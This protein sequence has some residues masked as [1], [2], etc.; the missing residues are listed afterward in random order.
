VNLTDQIFEANRVGA[1][2]VT[3]FRKFFYQFL[4]QLRADGKSRPNGILGTGPDAFS[5]KARHAT[6][7]VAAKPR[8]KLLPIALVKWLSQR[9]WVIWKW[10]L[11][12]KGE[13]TKVLYQARHPSSAA[14][15][16]D[17]TTWATYTEARRACPEVEDGGIGFVIT[18]SEWAALDL[19][20]CCDAETGVI[21]EWALRLMRKSRAY[22]EITPSGTGVR[23]IGTTLRTAPDSGRKT[24]KG[25]D[26]GFEHP[27]EGIEVFRR[28]T[29]RYIT[30]TGDEHTIPGRNGHCPRLPNI[31]SI[32]ND[33]L[34]K[35]A[36]KLSRPASPHAASPPP[37]GTPKTSFLGAMPGQ[38]RYGP[39]ARNHVLVLL[40][41]ID[42]NMDRDRWRNVVAALHA[43][44]I[45]D[46]GAERWLRQ[47]AQDWSIGK[48]DR[49]ERY[50]DGTPT[51][52]TGP[53]AVDQVFDTMPPVE[54]RIG[55][56]TLV[57]MAREA[58][59]NGPA[60]PP[61]R[62]PFRWFPDQAGAPPWPKR[63][64]IELV[65]SDLI[66][67]VDDA[68]QALIEQGVDIF[69]Q[70]DR[71][72][73]LAASENPMSDEDGSMATRLVDVPKEALV[74]HMMGA[75]NFMKMDARTN[76]L[77]L[78]DCPEK[79][80]LTYMARHGRR[81][82]RPMAG[83]INSPTMRRD[84]TILDQPGYDVVTGLFYDPGQTIFP[85]IPP[86]P[87]RADA[88]AALGILNAL[89][90]TFPFA[91]PESRA[92]AL[93]AMLTTT[94]RRLLPTAPMHGFSAP[95]PSSGKTKL[96]NIA[97]MIATGR[98]AKTTTQSKE[99]ETEKRLASLFL[100]GHAA[101]LLDNCTLPVGGDALCAMLTSEKYS[102]R[103][104]GK[105]EMHEVQTN[106]M[107]F[108]TGNNLVIKD[109]MNR[110]SLV[111]TIDPQV[112][113]PEL[114]KFKNDP[115]KDAQRERGRYLAAVITILRAHV[116]AGRPQMETPLGSFEMWSTCVRDA[117]I[118]LDEAD[119]CATMEAT[120][121]NDPGHEKLSALIRHWQAVHGENRVTVKH[122]IK[123][124]QTGTDN[125]LA[126][127]G[128]NDAL[129]AVAV[130]KDGGISPGR[131]GKYL[132]DIRGKV[133]GEYRIV[134]EDKLLH[135]D[136]PWRL[137]HCPQP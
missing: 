136:R 28:T 104:L 124:A 47:A 25:A 33:T 77:K 128:L 76:N 12:E 94:V 126:R 46:D 34:V 85:A 52:Y 135:G 21:K 8:V 114:R 130:A 81:N 13:R 96:V 26:H 18:D 95:T 27:K 51:L 75:A 69:Q 78:V 59:F 15:S 83:I 67:N 17:D 127:Q 97:A 115:Q 1:R 131:L 103:V 106:A 105:S 71:I 45:D 134:R 120:R 101:I 24:F 92:V 102:V 125:L 7:S 86:Q 60:N 73:S 50:K 10:V 88:M 5:E 64:E 87:S 72:V 63:R 22:C 32:I 116:V 29:G 39:V 82:L 53:E 41:H 107:M 9:R 11:R 110:R 66:A 57:Y 137:E 44:R 98:E 35:Y 43:T 58:G 79:I 36:D 112:E 40:S 121:A 56:G 37:T 123:A 119:P 84:G 89:I 118:W 2:P 90:R 65:R 48:L 54:G 133:I 109:D 99:E 6:A 93:S 91:T 132:S 61:A 42:P 16:N 117:L 68:E 74:E 129:M 62:E 20:H 70:G 108:A 14:R 49:L 122:V 100:A 30:V 113:R 4:R 80:A 3:R 23:I 111:C 38:R 55:Y 31:D 19:D